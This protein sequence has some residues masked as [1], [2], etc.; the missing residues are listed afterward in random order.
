MYRVVKDSSAKSAE[1]PVCH[2]TRLLLSGG[3]LKCT[4]CG[5]LIGVISNNKYGAKKTE[6]GGHRYDSRFESECAE[7]LDTRL[8]AKDIAKVERQVKIDLRAYGEHITNYFIDF[9][10]THNDGHKEYVES[11]GMESDTWKL[12]WKMMESKLKHEE[13]DAELTLWKQKSYKKV[14]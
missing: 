9:V 4:N 3:K 14:R 10:I 7:I 12:K 8:R 2:S 6:Y 5:E 11:K 13:P 1:C